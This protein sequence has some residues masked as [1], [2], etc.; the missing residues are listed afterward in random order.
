MTY[1]DLIE[2]IKKEGRVEADDDFDDFI[3]GV[4]NELYIEATEQE[5][6]PELRENF[7]Y[8][9]NELQEAI[10]LP[11]GYLKIHSVRFYPLNFETGWDLGS[12]S[13]VIEPAPPGFFGYPKSYEIR[14][15]LIQISP[16]DGVGYGDT[17]EITFYG[18]P[19]FINSTTR[20]NEIFVPRLEPYLI[21]AAL[22]RVHLYHSKVDLAQAY[23][24][25][26]AEGGKAFQAENNS[27]TVDQ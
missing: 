25:G 8:G 16:V 23:T 2:K 19:P 3:I 17:L 5:K 14:G 20:T 6:I 18:T 9:W 27:T 13:G 12:T 24:S 7:I 1:N 22:S 11:D 15:D 26:S 4:L 21:R 10:S